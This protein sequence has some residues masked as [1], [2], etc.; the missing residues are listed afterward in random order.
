MTSTKGKIPISCCDIPAGS[1][2]N[3]TCD[4]NSPG[5]HREG[6]LDAFSDYI[7]GHAVSIE[8][9]G[10]TLAIIQVK[11]WTAAK[12]VFTAVVTNYGFFSATWYYFVLLLIQ[13]D[14]QRLR[15]CLIQLVI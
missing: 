4:L 14:S 6:C 1:F 15:N 11:F 7:E 8:S 12:L 10:L 13:A 9:V 5:L 2:W 3:V